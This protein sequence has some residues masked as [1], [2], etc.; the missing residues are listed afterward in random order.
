MA[1][2]GDNDINTTNI[3]A[4]V[5]NASD[6]IRVLCTDS[7]INPWSRGRPGYLTVT[8]NVIAYQA[9]R[10]TSY[11]DPRGTYG[12]SLKEVYHEGDYRQ[13]DDDAAA[14]K[15]RNISDTLY[16][17]DGSTG[18]AYKSITV[19]MERVQFSNQ[20]GLS[21]HATLNNFDY[22]YIHVLRDDGAGGSYTDVAQFA[23]SSIGPD[24]PDLGIAGPISVPYT[25][26]AVGSSTTYNVKIAFGNTGVSG[27]YQAELG[28]ASGA[29]GSDTMK[30]SKALGPYGIII[31]DG[32]TATNEVVTV[33]RG[34]T[35]LNFSFDATVTGMAYF[36]LEKNNVAHSTPF[37][38]TIE[39]GYTGSFTITAAADGDVYKVTVTYPFSP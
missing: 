20:D 9:P 23:I 17:S 25:I 15:L 11:T 19:D 38:D 32:F 5:G 30:I 6:I 39:Y 7:T 29:V 18:T 21:K 27:V 3:G 35:T 26:P 28:S 2:L 37:P 22:D 14:P 31:D 10:G 36:E 13:Y 4:E 24:T 1:G 12:G 33:S 16:A 34:S 8:S